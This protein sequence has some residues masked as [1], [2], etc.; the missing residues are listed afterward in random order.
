M[1][2]L[3][4]SSYEA[5]HAVQTRSGP[6]VLTE[7][8]KRK[9]LEL[10][11]R[12]G[13]VLPLDDRQKV[14]DCDILY[15]FLIGRNWVVEA[16]EASLRTYASL[17]KKKKLNG[18]IAEKFSK[19]VESTASLLYGFD[20]DGLPIMWNTPDFRLL[21]KLLKSGL[22]SDLLRVQMQVMEKARFLAKE[23]HVDR[24][25]LV[26][27]L[28]HTSISSV[29]SH[30]LAFAREFSKIMQEYYPEIMRRMLVFNAGWAVTGAWKVVKPLLDQRVQEKVH[31]FSG[32]PSMEALLPFIDEDQVP[33]SRGGKGRRDVVAEMIAAEVERVRC[34]SR[35]GAK[36]HLE[37]LTPSVKNASMA[38]DATNAAMTPV[39][40]PSCIHQDPTG[41]AGEEVGDKASAKSLSPHEY[42]RHELGTLERLGSS[43]S[44]SSE[45][46]EVFSLY[47][48]LGSSSEDGVAP[49]SL[50]IGSPEVMNFSIN[51]GDGPAIGSANE[52]R[53][54]VV[55]P[56]S[57]QMSINLVWYANGK[58]AGFCDR[59]LIGELEHNLVY[60][61]PEGVVTDSHVPRASPASSPFPSTSGGVQQ[62]V[63]MGELLG[64]SGH[65]IH[66]HVIVCDARRRA[67]FVLR[68]GRLRRS[69]QVFQF[70][71]GANVVTDSLTRHTAVGE[72][73]K[74]AVCVPYRS[75]VKDPTAW[76]MNSV[77]AAAKSAKGDVRQQRS[78]KRLAEKQGQTLTAYGKLAELA[79]VDLFTLLVGVCGMWEA[80]LRLTKVVD[81]MAVKTCF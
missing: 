75:A 77:G 58:V 26:L 61:F 54:Q 72:R 5:D 60:G 44:T 66:H 45:G 52:Q 49:V 71:S 70:L 24:C 68:K 27:D 4:N 73:V 40:L 29:N 62:R 10:H 31:F 16:A 28:R 13:D 37:G 81:G 67:R 69:V 18:I 22:K 2:E 20:K 57:N 76:V 33:P 12:L 3:M 78:P 23:R 30:T 9:N 38:S 51:N 79:P 25:T 8:H 35:K 43:G 41:I 53:A 11:S 48:C 50:Q 74:L 80:D 17:R 42:E 39:L 14:S 32:P 1:A 21:V 59:K 6:T 36:T 64:E 56:E 19:G 55:S 65:R 34:G 46:L 63:L 47:S 15:R 7:E